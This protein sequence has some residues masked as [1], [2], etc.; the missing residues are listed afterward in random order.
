MS[1]LSFKSILESLDD[2]NALHYLASQLPKI[3][4]SEE[5]QIIIL[6]YILDR[7]TLRVSPINDYLDNPTV[8]DKIRKV[9]DT[10]EFAWMEVINEGI[11]TYTGYNYNLRAI[12]Q[13]PV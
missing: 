4:F 1:I 12:G 5:N 11:F 10:W 7:F 3:Y 2:N 8:E 9:I 13:F 6:R